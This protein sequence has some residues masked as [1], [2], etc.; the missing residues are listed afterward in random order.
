M[1][2]WAILNDVPAAAVAPNLKPLITAAFG[3]AAAAAEP[4]LAVVH[5]TQ[6]DELFGFSALHAAQNHTSVATGLAQMLALAA[7][8]AA[9]AAAAATAGA[10]GAAGAAAGAAAVSVAGL[11]APNLKPPVAAGVLLVM[12]PPSLGAAAAAVPGL[13]VVHATQADE[14]FGFSALHA[15]QNHTSV[16]A[17][18][19]QMLDFFG[20]AAGAGASAAGSLAAATASPAAASPS[21]AALLAAGSFSFSSSTS[22]AALPLRPRAGDFFGEASLARLAG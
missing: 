6:A 4:G 16:A 8:G 3:A 19:A 13:A 11:V 15:V 14:L 21:P 22:S 18:L 17:G 7:G 2:G 1:M 12:T 5:A 10:S 9:A 20:A